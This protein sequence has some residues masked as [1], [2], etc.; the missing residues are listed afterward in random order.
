MLT[1]PFLF[2][3]S[4]FLFIICFLSAILWSCFFPPLDFIEFHS[5]KVELMYLVFTLPC[6]SE[7][8]QQIVRLAP[9]EK[10]TE[11]KLMIDISR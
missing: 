3:F 7:N 5:L 2:F 11:I 1:G 8:A 6:S 4:F 9:R 10:Y